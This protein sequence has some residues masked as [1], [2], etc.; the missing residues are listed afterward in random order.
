MGTHKR[1]RERTLAFS[2]GLLD[3][4]TNARQN[5][6]NERDDIVGRPIFVTR[7]LSVLQRGRKRDEN[8]DDDD[9]RCDHHRKGLPTTSEASSV[10]RRCE[11]RRENHVFVDARDGGETGDGWHAVRGEEHVRH[12]VRRSRGESG[13]YRET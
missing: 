1:A 4:K 12:P 2:L 11:T 9:E 3:E 7:L 13:G 6:G 10:S 8:G 5:W